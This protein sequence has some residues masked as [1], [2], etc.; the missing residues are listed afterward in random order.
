MVCF[1]M[2]SSTVRA[3]QSTLHSFFFP[4]CLSETFVRERITGSK[5]LGR[6]FEDNL[7][8]GKES[9]KFSGSRRAFIKL[10]VQHLSI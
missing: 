1:F 6:Y 7:G 8:I 5:N 9:R 2:L 10:A 4:L 3:V